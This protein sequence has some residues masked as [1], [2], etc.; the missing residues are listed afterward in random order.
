MYIY[1]GFDIII[2]CGGS[3]SNSTHTT[4]KVY[5]CEN[6]LIYDGND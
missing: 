4:E 3:E 5:L 2:K 1:Y 6:D